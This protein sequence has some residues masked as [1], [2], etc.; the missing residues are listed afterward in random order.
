MP[1]PLQL[2]RVIYPAGALGGPAFVGALD[3]YASGLAGAWSVSRRLLTSYSGPLVR[4]R[5]SSDNA[6]QDIGFLLEHILA[7]KMCA[8]CSKMVQYNN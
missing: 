1:S 2:Q 7:P 5:R 6:E 3:A 4:V 8:V